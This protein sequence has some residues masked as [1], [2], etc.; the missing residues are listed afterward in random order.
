MVTISW[1]FRRRPRSPPCGVGGSCHGVT[2][3]GAGDTWLRTLRRRTLWRRPCPDRRSIP[4]RISN[5]GRPVSRHRST[6][7]R[8]EPLRRSTPECRSSEAPSNQTRG[9]SLPSAVGHTPIASLRSHRL[10]P[11][12]I[13]PGCRACVGPNGRFWAGIGPGSTRVVV[14]APTAVVSA[15]AHLDLAEQAAASLRSRFL[16]VTVTDDVAGVE[17]ASAYTNVVAIAVGICEGIADRLGQSAASRC[18]PV[19]RPGAA[20]HRQHG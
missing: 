18:R 13:H 8:S 5:P 7:R 3:S 1:S 6:A 15:S 14:G 17:T 11:L 2:I 9:D 20:G 4:V 10:P 19:T 16:A 12:S